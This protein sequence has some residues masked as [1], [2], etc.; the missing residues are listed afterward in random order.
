[1]LF[2]EYDLKADLLHLGERP[3][4]GIFRPC[5]KTIPFSQ[6]SGA[7]NAQFGRN[8]FK[9][10]G[11]LSGNGDFNS[12]SYLTYSPRDRHLGLSKVPLQVEYLSN[13]SASIIVSQNEAAELLPSEFDLLLGGLRSRGFGGCHL[14]KRK[15]LDGKRVMPGKLNVRIPCTERDPFNV[16][17]VI[18]PIYGYLFK[19]LPNHYTGEYVLAYFE[20]SEVVAPSFLLKEEGNG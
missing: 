6:I 10:V 8:D 17:N 1:M 19:P 5:L 15:A 3:K 7:L 9:A 16:R 13:V 2:V 12:S 11:Y 18:Q 20:G 4:G 14:T